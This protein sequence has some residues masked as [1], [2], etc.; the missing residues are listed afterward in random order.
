MMHAPT[1]APSHLPQGGRLVAADGRTLP[2]MAAAITGNASGGIA[3]VVVEQR[4]RNPHDVPLTVTYSVPLPPDAAVSGYAFRVGDRRIVGEIDRRE[5]ARERFEEAVLE[6]K[7]AAL[8]EQDRSS[9]F[10]QEIANVP[11]GGEVVA[12]VTLDQR[13]RFLQEGEWEWRFPRTVAPRYLGE[14]GRVADGPRVTQEVADAPLPVR[15]TL[16]FVVRDALVMGRTAESPS[17]RIRVEGGRVVFADEAGGPLDRDVVVRWAVA[18]PAVGVRIDV[19]RPPASSARANDAFAL[20]TL[21]PPR[22]DVRP[23]PVARDVVVLLDTSGSMLGEPLDQ[24]RRIVGALI[25]TLGKEDQLEMIEFSSA[26]LRWKQGAVTATAAHRRDAH[27]WLAGLRAM[28]STEMH[29]AIV[30]ALQPLRAESQRQ[31][32]LVTD[33][34]VGFESQVI[35]EIVS[36]LPRS[37][38]V[39]TVGVGSA[40]NR[41]LTSAAARAGRGVEVITGLG[42][43]PERAVWRIVAHTDAPA[44]VDLAVEGAALLEHAPHKLPDLFAGAPLIVAIRSRPEGGELVV[45]GRTSSGPWES[46]VQLPPTRPGDGSQAVVALFGREAVEDLDVELAAGTERALVDPKVEAIGLQYQIA[47]RLTSWV[48]IAEEPS[49]DPREPMKRVRIPHELPHGLSVEG[50][51][52]RTAT[53]ASAWMAS[54]A[55][56]GSGMVAGT[57]S[58]ASLQMM[59]RGRA[60]GPSVLSRAT[61]AGRGSM[62]W[63][64]KPDG[65][66][67]SRSGASSRPRTEGEPAQGVP[68]PSQRRLPARVVIHREDQIVIEAV[69]HGGDLAWAPADRAVV[70]WSDRL[71]TSH[72][73]EPALSTRAGAVKE[74]ESLRIVLS[75]ARACGTPRIIEIACGSLQLVLIF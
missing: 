55:M 54:A 66:D 70:V 59:S 10:T 26:A 15:A 49:V 6:G 12:E 21:V 32:V 30:E 13:L 56:F 35:G 41:T 42:E 4:F 5:A 43:D 18:L 31:V 44:V 46:R 48:A 14:P 75:V 51:G 11:P 69:V 17:D 25:D 3:R 47:T 36:R 68:L 1:P 73:L 27:R 62:G 58:L 7:T 8:L 23:I 22:G 50:L 57:P 9:L 64:E 72:P 2:L 28:G 61:G 37:S 29:Q 38:R 71:P 20:L 33:G 34:Q 65:A 63:D 39:H 74:G 52:L 53:G 16:D 40:V 60:R 45:R 67:P 24:A 19:A